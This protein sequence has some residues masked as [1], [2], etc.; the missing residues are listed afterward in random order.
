MV[1]R[2]IAIIYGITSKLPHGN[3]LQIC[4]ISNSTSSILGHKICQMIMCLTCT[5]GVI[6]P[7]IGVAQHAT[8]G[9][10]PFGNTQ[11]PQGVGVKIVHKWGTLWEFCTSHAVEGCLFGGYLLARHEL[12]ASYIY[13]SV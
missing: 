10:G 8:C 13:L 9:G 6:R 4:S 11:V 3:S 2:I 12:K 1:Y 7:L 5:K